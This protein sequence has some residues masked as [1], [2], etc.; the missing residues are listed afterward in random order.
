MTPIKIV[1]WDMIVL[2]GNGSTDNTYWD[3]F[4]ESNELEPGTWSELSPVFEET[5]MLTTSKKEKIGF[6]IKT[7]D[8]WKVNYFDTAYVT[9]AS[10]NEFYLD[11]NV[12]KPS[13]PG[14]NVLFLHFK[15]SSNRKAELN[16]Y[17]IAGH[18]V[19]NVFDDL[20][21]A[22]W[23]FTT[24]DGTDERDEPVGSGIYLAIISSGSYNKYLK[25]ILIR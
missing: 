18:F 25:F 10:N 13:E 4:I 6:I 19:K 23:N 2:F 9:I 15:L 12:F 8:F 20:G 1:S 11:H 24:W 17:D 22:G 3:D 14:E 21:V 5:E 16:I 7:E